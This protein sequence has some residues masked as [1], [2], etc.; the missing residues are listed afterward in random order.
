[1]SDV[2]VGTHRSDGVRYR[3]V[4]TKWIG[5]VMSLSLTPV[6]RFMAGRTVPRMQ[7]GRDSIAASWSRCTHH[8][9]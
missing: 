7:H 3:A 9:V 4:S 1:M 8:D 5:D 2:R 6:Q